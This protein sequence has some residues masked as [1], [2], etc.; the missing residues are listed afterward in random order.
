MKDLMAMTPKQPIADAGLS[1]GPHPQQS[2]RSGEQA[3]D[4]PARLPLMDTT[5]IAIAVQTLIA[6]EVARQTAEVWKR[7]RKLEAKFDQL[8]WADALREP[9][10]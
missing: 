4:S 1:I 3:T 9:P 6:E 5:R 7:V 8:K 10:P 2:G